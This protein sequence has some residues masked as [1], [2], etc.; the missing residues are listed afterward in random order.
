MALFRRGQQQPA[1]PPADLNAPDPEDR[2]EALQAHLSAAVTAVNRASGH[3]PT[4]SQV[5]AL[6]LTDV[7]GQIVALAETRPLDIYAAITVRK[8][9]TEYLPDTL[10][11]FEQ[12]PAAAR[13]LPRPS[14]KTPAVALRE[15]LAAM[16]QA[17]ETTLEAAQNHDVDALMTQGTFLTTKFSRSDLDL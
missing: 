11:A 6:Y 17:A 2:P 3:L 4:Y 9:L 10:R 14:G 7:L 5:Q 15:S 12:V 13:H 16:L 8:T 1:A